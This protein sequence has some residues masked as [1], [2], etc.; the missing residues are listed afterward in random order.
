MSKLSE[1]QI[2]FLV[3][4]AEKIIKPT[5]MWTHVKSGGVYKINGFTFNVATKKLDVKYSPVFP[6]S[7]AFF[8]FNRDFEEF[9]DGRFVPYIKPKRLGALRSR[10]S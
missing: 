8:E 9:S 5:S 10:K 2:L 3:K 7:G 1:E 4:D 6:K